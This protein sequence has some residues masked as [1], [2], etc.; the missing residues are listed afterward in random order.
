[1]IALGAA[2]V[3]L[4]SLAFFLPLPEVLSRIAL[5]VALVLLFVSSVLY[6]ISWWRG[7]GTQTR[8]F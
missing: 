1:V 2:A 8:P 3:L 7:R 6:Q 4:G 5:A